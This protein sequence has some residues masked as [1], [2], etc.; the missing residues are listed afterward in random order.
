MLLG[1]E[2]LGFGM[3]NGVFKS[4]Y[5]GKFLFWSDSFLAALFSL[6]FLSLLHKLNFLFL[7]GSFD[8]GERRDESATD[9]VLSESL[10]ADLAGFS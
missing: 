10:S 6:D 8:F 4:T 7:V 3:S 1:L 2:N 9:S 5:L